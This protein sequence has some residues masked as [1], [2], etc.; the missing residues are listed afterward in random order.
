LKDEYDQTRFLISTGGFERLWQHLWQ[1]VI[2]FDLK[3]G[4]NTARWVNVPDFPKDLKNVEHLRRYRCSL[5]SELQTSFNAAADILAKHN[6]REQDASF[7][8]LGCG[9]GKP[10]ILAALHHEFASITGIDF[11][12]GL[13]EIANNNIQKVAASQRRQGNFKKCKGLEE[14]KVVHGDV[15]DFKDYADTSVV[16]MYFPFDEEITQQ[17]RD[18]IEK[19]NAKS[20]VIYNYPNHENVFRDNNW[21]LAWK[22]IDSN[23]DQ[24]TKIYS[25]GFDAV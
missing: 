23:P 1:N 12:P 18:N 25:F 5:Q 9:K 10:L 21:Q 7:Y 6:I 15:T 13:V 17:V 3:Y 20:L 14:I 19:R 4:T 2:S 24:T 22:K 8:D 11:H 16:Y